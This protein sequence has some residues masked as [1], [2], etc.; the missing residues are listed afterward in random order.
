MPGTSLLLDVR[1]SEVNPSSDEVQFRAQWMA[2]LRAK[3]LSSRCAVVVSPRIYQFGVAMMARTYLEFQGMT[4]E[5]FADV[6]EAQ[7]WLSISAI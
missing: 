4:L 3:G 2:S 5:I 6:H 1:Q 7:R